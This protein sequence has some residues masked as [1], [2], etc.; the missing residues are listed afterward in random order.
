MP[1]FKK[2]KTNKMVNQVMKVAEETD[3]D[4]KKREIPLDQIDLNPDNESVFGY[5]DIDYLAENI[6]EDGFTGAIEVYAK[7]DGRY[8]ISSGHRRYLAAKKNGMKSIPCIVSADVDDVTKAKKLIKSNVL[9]R[10]MS[11]LKW[12]KALRYYEKNVL[13]DFKGGKKRTELARVFNLSEATVARYEMLLKL[14]PEFQEIADNESFPYAN[15]LS[16]TGLETDKQK[17]IYENLVKISA[18]EDGD[19][20]KLSKSTIDTEVNAV[21]REL[22]IESLG[23]INNEADKSAKMNSLELEFSKDMEES[24]E[25]QETNNGTTRD[26]EDR[27]EYEVDFVSN[28]NVEIA[29]MKNDSDEVWRYHVGILMDYSKDDNFKKKDELKAALEEILENL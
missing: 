1:D 23:K 16:I 19:L 13:Q 9:S 18:R 3:L 24:G 2:A 22:E 25:P 11:P 27:D 20:T 8:E 29:S 4:N 12:G 26:E 17:Q 5:D 15:F 6:Q 14:I 21:K 7:K 10:K 28:N